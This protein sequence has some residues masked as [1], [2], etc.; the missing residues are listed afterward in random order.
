MSR[1]TRAAVCGSAALALATMVGWS[2]AAHAQT[3]TLTMS[4]WVPP[5]H[6]LTKD[7]LSV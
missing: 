3:T 6:L 2:P 5:S 1:F 4:S 7:V